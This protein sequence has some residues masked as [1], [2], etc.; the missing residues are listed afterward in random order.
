MCARRPRVFARAGGTM[1]PHRWNRRHGISKGEYVMAVILTWYH[2]QMARLGVT[3]AAG[4]AETMK[5]NL[6]RLEEKRRKA[7]L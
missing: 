3:N 1:T 4:K 2:Q 7:N 6:D 5:Y